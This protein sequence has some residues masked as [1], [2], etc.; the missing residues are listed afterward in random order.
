MQRFFSRFAWRN[1][2]IPR[3][4]A[5]MFVSLMVLIV[6]M[7]LLAQAGQVLTRRQLQTSLAAAVEMQAL[8]QDMQTSVESMDRLEGRLVEQQYGW[9][10]F[11]LTR[12][13]LNREYM[14]TAESIQASTTQ[15][16]ALAGNILTDDE[17]LASLRQELRETEAVVADSTTYFGDMLDLVEELVQPTTG[18]LDQLD[19]AGDRLEAETV[20]LED[21]NLLG[22]LVLMRNLERT[23]TT[24]TE[25]SVMEDLR[26][27][28]QGYL[29]V[30]A[31]N[32]PGG[33]D[34]EIEQLVANYIDRAEVVSGQLLRL[35]ATYTASQNRKN[36]A[37]NSISRLVT[38]TGLQREAQLDAVD[39][40]Q[41]SFSVVLFGSL[42]V[43]L[44]IAGVMTY[45]FGRALSRSVN[46]L[47][48]PIEQFEL[49]DFSARAEVAGN[50]EFSQMAAGFN[51]MAEQIEDLVDNLEQRIAERTRDLNITANIGR[52][53][54]T[55]RDP[56]ALMD[57][58]VELIRQRFGYYHVQV[59]LVDPVSE[60]A[61]LV[62]STGAP[63]RELLARQHALDV[64][65]KSV[66]GQVTARGEPVVARDTDTSDVH[67]RN[68]LLPDT[69]SEMAL[70]MRA[71]DAIIGALDVQ[72][73]APDAFD[74]DVVAVFQIMADQLAVAL[75]NARLL[76]QL[77]DTRAA[78][79]A[80]ERNIT[81]EAWTA[82]RQ[83]RSFDAPAGFEL[84]EERVTPQRSPAPTP[85]MRAIEEGRILRP[86]NGDGTLA[87]PIKVRGEAIGAFAFSG[88]SLRDL[89][90]ADLSLVEA[91]VDRVGLTL[92]SMRLVE[93][94]AR[95]AENEQVLNEVTAR[96]VGSTDVNAILQTAVKE[97]GRVLRAP[98]TT[99]QLRQE[100]VSDDF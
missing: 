72:S 100:G 39:A 48:T 10:S 3:K 79:N 21:A 96:L 11:E 87:V 51:T 8:S 9:S 75:E 45:F 28:S 15:I 92:E 59:F 61:E 52:A 54:S 55:Q 47:L 76:S 6:L 34:A 84:A 94:T 42:A 86:Q 95:R 33:S 40:L 89:S 24:R 93:E 36:S 67:S 19:S 38:L 56:R 18:A 23:L 63:G 83:A 60:R 98:Q 57:E 22:E 80:L 46:E 73:V 37:R 12:S 16:D 44:A 99:V 13:R 65:S 62:A 35:R 85:L 88:E 2:S 68:E 14:E 31:R 49:G 74:E 97:L 64:G 5:V 20:A 78:M 17:V 25:Q 27:A 91:I 58:I 30:Y 1:L 41:R 81:L 32:H 43:M 53:V 71:G 70:P 26:D 4:T 66:I 7:A 77:D 69:R 50:D 29:E 90:E 82:Y